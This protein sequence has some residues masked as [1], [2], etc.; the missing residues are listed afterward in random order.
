MIRTNSTRI[1]HTHNTIVEYIAQIIHTHNTIVEYI[2]RITATIYPELVWRKILC[3]S[4]FCKDS[5]AKKG[6]K[7]QKERRVHCGN[8]VKKSPECGCALQN[9]PLIPLACHI[10]AVVDKSQEKSSWIEEI[11]H[12][13]LFRNRRRGRG[14][15]TWRVLRMRDGQTC[16][17]FYDARPR[18]GRRGRCWLAGRHWP[19]GWHQVRRSQVQLHG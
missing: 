18:S 3:C 6:Q 17:C 13:L 15:S 5:E 7:G 1:I 10:H 9:T 14:P 12:R 11:C 16:A 19:L 4:G 2:A 8:H